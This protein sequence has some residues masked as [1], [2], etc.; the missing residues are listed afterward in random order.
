[1]GTI[2]LSRNTGVTN[3]VEPL[4][5]ILPNKAWFTV[6]SV[7]GQ[8]GML[9]LMS[10]S[11]AI[12]SLLAPGHVGSWAICGDLPMDYLSAATIKHPR[13]ALLAFADL[14]KRGRRIHA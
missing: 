6:R 13:K 3:V 4:P 1:M 10:R 11:G 14:W 7:L 8:R 12:E 2:L 5:N 9:P